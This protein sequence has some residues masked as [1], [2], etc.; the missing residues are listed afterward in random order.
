[1]LVVLIS[2]LTWKNINNYLNNIST[3]KFTLLW[4]STTAFGVMLFAYWMHAFEGPGDKSFFDQELYILYKALTQDAEFAVGA[5]EKVSYFV[6]ITN[7]E[8]FL[9]HLG[10]LIFLGIGIIGT[11]IWLKNKDEF[12]FPLCLSMVVLFVII[13][14]FSLFG[15][16]AFLP[17]RWFSFVYILLALVS[18]FGVF[19]LSNLI[20]K[21]NSGKL[22]S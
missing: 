17:P 14:G 5:A 2:L 8:I 20:N 12:K 15:I 9:N 6:P 1:M 10:Y 11:Y 16:N 3:H 13:Y 7:L 22:L 18:A 19:K 21:K 4:S